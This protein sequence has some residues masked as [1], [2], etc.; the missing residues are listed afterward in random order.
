MPGQ[1]MVS[2]MS[3]S[4]VLLSIAFVALSC[5]IVGCGSSSPKDTS[6]WSY[7]PPDEFKQQDKQN[8]GATVFLGPIDD[9]FKANLQVEAQTNDS[10][11]A[12][13]IAQDALDKAKEQT[14]VTVIEQESYALADSDSYTWM[15]SRKLPTGVVA[16]QR[17]FFVKKNKVVVRFLMTASEKSMPKWDQVLAD[18]LKSFKWGR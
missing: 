3:K 18:S 11:T 2:E 1:V 10:K 4:F 13:Q 16:E 12:Q 14:D 6:D 8:K 7:N 15:I 17:Q 5:S 9:G